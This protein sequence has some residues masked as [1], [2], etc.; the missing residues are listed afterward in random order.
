MK[1]IKFQVE[2]NDNIIDVE[3]DGNRVW[4][5]AHFQE[6]PEGYMTSLKHLFHKIQS[7][8]NQSIIKNRSEI[9]TPKL[10]MN[11]AGLSDVLVQTKSPDGLE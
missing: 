11:Q 10:C 4:V 1:L 2:L 6:L 3:H 5:D 7:T 9:V 8:I